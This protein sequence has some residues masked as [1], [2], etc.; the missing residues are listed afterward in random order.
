MSSTNVVFLKPKARNREPH[1]TSSN[2]HYASVSSIK[3]VASKPETKALNRLDDF[4]AA[5]IIARRASQKLTKV[6]F[7]FDKASAGKILRS[8]E[9]PQIVRDVFVREIVSVCEAHKDAWVTRAKIGSTVAHD[10]LSV[11]VDAQQ[12]ESLAR[13]LKRVPNVK[14]AYVARA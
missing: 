13:S 7:E 14:Q 2:G 6:I 4:S 11:E 3:R 9:R 1:A 5:A 12:A 10:A 8:I